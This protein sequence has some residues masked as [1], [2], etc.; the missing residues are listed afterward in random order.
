MAALNQPR[1]PV[2][3][4]QEGLPRRLQTDPAADL[5]EARGEAAQMAEVLGFSGLTGRTARGR[6][7]QRDPKRQ[8]RAL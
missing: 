5:K 1:W 2:E 6:Q 7:A 4:G 8:A 3:A